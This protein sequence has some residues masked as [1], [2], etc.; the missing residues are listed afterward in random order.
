[1]MTITSSVFAGFVDGNKIYNGLIS[2]DTTD[3]LMS[4]YYIFGVVDTRFTKCI[5]GDVQGSQV[6]DVVKNYLSRNPEKRQYLA[7]S[8]IENAIREKFNCK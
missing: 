4:N 3:I 1:M 7:S 6:F 2:G 5:P 8:L